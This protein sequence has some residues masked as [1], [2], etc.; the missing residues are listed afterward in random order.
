MLK[1][2]YRRIKTVFKYLLGKSTRVIFAK[3]NKKN[4]YSDRKIICPFKSVNDSN[5]RIY[6]LLV[7][8]SII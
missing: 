5:N 3:K 7:D 8:F 4:K 2:K 1:H 6:K